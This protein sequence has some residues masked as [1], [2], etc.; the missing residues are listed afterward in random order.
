MFLYLLL[1]YTSCVLVF[2]N[3][4]CF[5]LNFL[6]IKNKSNYKQRKENDLGNN[7]L[8]S[9]THTVKPLFQ[10]YTIW[11][12]YAFTSRL[13][14]LSIHSCY[15]TF[16]VIFR[17]ASVLGADRCLIVFACE[18]K[19]FCSNYGKID[20]MERVQRRPKCRI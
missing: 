5:Y 9:N 15:Q 14:T 8:N 18:L 7:T 6:S 11:S 16:M 13:E 10:N 17:I 3:K 12:F 1:I 19:Y 4:K 2:N 20:F